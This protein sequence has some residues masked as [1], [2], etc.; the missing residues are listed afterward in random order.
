MSHSCLSLVISV[1]VSHCVSQIVMAANNTTI[2]VLLRKSQTLANGEHAV[3]L[4]VTKDRVRKYTSL[5]FTCSLKDWDTKTNLP[6]SKH[7]YK[8]HYDSIIA[9]AIKE[10]KDKLADFKQDGKDF[11]PAVL[12]DTVT[13]VTNKTTLFR[14]FESKIETLK[15]QNRIG[16]ADVYTNAFHQL[17]KFLKE[18]DITFSQIDLIFLQKFETS[19][20][21]R[22][23]M[24][25]AISIH[26]RT[27]RAVFNAAIAE[28]YA[29]KD[30]YPFD[31]YK[32]SD[33]F[34]TKTKKRAITKEEILKVGALILN[35]NSTEYEA[36]QYF[37]FTYYGT[38][39]NFVDIANLQW[40]NLS[41]GRIFY[42]RAKTGQELS[43]ALSQP[44]LEIIDRLNKLTDRKATSYIFPI[45]NRSVHVTPTQI[46]NRIKKVMS[47]VNIDLKAIGASVEIETPLTTYVARH[48]FAT[49]LKRS[50]VATA[51]ISESMG[52]ATEAVTQTYL[53]SF[54]N[55]ILDEAMKNLL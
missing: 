23:M 54:E 42:K 49:V 52:H 14:Y 20:R 39:I 41:N 48:S 18:K 28:G 3:R 34:S 44:A 55:S 10:H 1:C 38:G 31:K 8:A 33:R 45:L 5:G 51:L 16:N 7:P 12:L 6:K 46:K 50:G 2:T 4:C 9:K 53:K 25:N 11:T 26:F 36:Q 47:R 37:M 21:K 24:D 32:I 22:G 17:K 30:S 29:R 35:P 13:T 27:L 40:K 43:F 19:F 15:E